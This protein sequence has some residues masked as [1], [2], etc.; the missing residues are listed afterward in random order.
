MRLNNLS[1]FDFLWN[2]WTWIATCVWFFFFWL[3]MSWLPDLFW[4]YNPCHKSWN[5]CVIF[6][7]PNVDLG[8]T[9]VSVLQNMHGL[10]LGKERDTFVRERRCQEWNLEKIQD[11][12][13]LFQ[14]FVTSIVFSWKRRNNDRFRSRWIFWDR[15]WKICVFFFFSCTQS[16]IKKKNSMLNYFSCMTEWQMEVRHLKYICNI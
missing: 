16:K 4:S 14:R 12:W 10:T 6:P 3:W 2:A 11:K 8:I 5:T 13:L 7:F 9:V 1:F 15:W